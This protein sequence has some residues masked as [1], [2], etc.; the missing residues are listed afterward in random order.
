[1]QNN[2][3]DNRS[4]IS[5]L[6]LR[7]S[8]GS[9]LIAHGMLKVVVF[10]VP[11]TVAYFESLGLPAIVAQLTIL[12]ELGLGLA[13]VLGLFTRLSALLA[14]PIMLGATWAH[15]ANGWLFSNQGGGWEFP[16]LLVALSI[17]VFIQGGGRFA[18]SRLSTNK[19]ASTWS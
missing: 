17:I 19:L 4:D 13:L 11:G 12:G 14:T 3:L 8:L 5:A 18:L 15:S 1:M 2:T 6:L 16:A 9:I 10:T 7:L